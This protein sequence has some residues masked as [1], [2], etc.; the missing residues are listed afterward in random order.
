MAMC[1]GAQ[2]LLWLFMFLSELG[3]KELEQDKPLIMF[4]DNQGALKMAQEGADTPRSKHIDIKYHFLKDLVIH[5]VIDVT[6][7]D[8]SLN[9]A[10]LM[11]KAKT[12]Q[13]HHHNTKLVLGLK[14]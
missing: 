4:G 9:L 7:I 5:E 1:V 6:Y 12:K 10:D 2:E 3:I 14:Q 11:T 13:P 8:T